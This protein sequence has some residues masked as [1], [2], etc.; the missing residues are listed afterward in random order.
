MRNFSLEF[1]IIAGVGLEN[2]KRKYDDPLLEAFPSILTNTEDSAK[3]PIRHFPIIIRSPNL[4]LNVA[5][6]R[7]SIKMKQTRFVVSTAALSVVSWTPLR[8]LGKSVAEFGDQNLRISWE[9][10]HFIQ[11]LH[12][13]KVP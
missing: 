10:F 1:A 6:P 4:R 2:R 7:A 13:S 9:I 12:P 5:N 8:S 3:G 11:F